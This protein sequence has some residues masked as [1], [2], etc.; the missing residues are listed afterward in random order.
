[1]K[2]SALAFLA[3]LSVLCMSAL[4]HPPESWQVI[5]PDG[6]DDLFCTEKVRLLE[7]GTSKT[8][9]RLPRTGRPRVLN[10]GPTRARPPFEVTYL[11]FGQR[12]RHDE[13]RCVDRRSGLTCRNRDGHGFWFGYPRGLRVF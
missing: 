10:H 5:F 4:A 13:W 6:N 12:W 1:M 11:A 9:V 3:S 7:C 8:T 2:L